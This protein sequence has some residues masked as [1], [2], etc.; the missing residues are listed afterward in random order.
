M[1]TLEQE[2]A[3]FGKLSGSAIFFGWLVALAVGVI[4]TGLFSAFGVAMAQ[5]S[6]LQHLAASGSVGIAG[7][8]LWLVTLAVSY[9]AG[10]YVA[11]R[12]ARYSGA[13]QGTGVWVLSVVIGIVVAILGAVLGASFNVL[14]YAHVTQIPLSASTLTVGGIVALVVSIVVGLVS[15]M[16]GGRAG[17]GYH[18]KID[19]TASYLRPS[20]MPQRTQ[21]APRR[22]EPTFG[23][24]IERRDDA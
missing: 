12:L 5:G 10:G 23:E 1:D 17:E 22:A 9:Y 11:G 14:R 2:R 7:A 18:R 20:E 4:L 15:A 13:K 3:L 21:P 16:A 8:V 24:R 19:R 6:S